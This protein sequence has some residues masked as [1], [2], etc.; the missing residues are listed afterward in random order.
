MN[1]NFAL[2]DAYYGKWV[3]AAGA[4]LVTTKGKKFLKQLHFKLGLD[5]KGQKQGRDEKTQEYNPTTE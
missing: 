4:L 3:H 2:A 5:V 1:D